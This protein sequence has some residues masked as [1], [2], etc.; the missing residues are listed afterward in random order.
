MNELVTFSI[1]TF[2]SFFTLINPLGTM[3]IFMTMTA[4]LDQQHRTNTARKASNGYAGGTTGKSQN[5]GI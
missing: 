4:D 5:K 1:L 3:P 2:T